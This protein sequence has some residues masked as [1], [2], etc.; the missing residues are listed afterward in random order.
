M[1]ITGP[2]DIKDPDSQ[3]AIGL[4]TGAGNRGLKAKNPRPPG[5]PAAA[6]AH[7]DQDSTWS[8]RHRA[9]NCSPVACDGRAPKLNWE[10][11][12]KCTEPACG[13]GI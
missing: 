3:S 11:P 5:L 7:R 12:S 1:T 4:L 8:K 2:C 10:I 13:R 9:V 6:E